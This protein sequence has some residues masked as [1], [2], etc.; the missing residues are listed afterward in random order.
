MN[1][2]L[3]IAL[4]Q[5]SIVWENPKANRTILSQKLNT[6]KSDVD[7]IILP[8]MFTSG[9]TMNPKNLEDSEGENTVAWMQE[10][11]ATKNMAI[12]GSIPFYENN[13]YTN[14][15]FFITADGE[16]Y[17]YDKKHTFTLA[18][19]DK[20]Y[21]SGLKRLIVSYKG[22]NICPMICYDLRFPVWARFKNDYDVLIYVANW[23]EP[24]IAAWDILL[25]A[26]AIENLSYCVGVNRIG[27]DENGLKYS[28]HSAVFDALGNQLCFST[29]EEVIYS[30]IE[31]SQL[32]NTR[33]KLM[34]LEDKDDF[35]FI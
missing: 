20:V 12:V 30:T 19:E 32:I 28:G 11:A 23:P 10:I 24:R 35:K 1:E 8:E 34:F 6:I 31:K 2:Q 16:K 3:N 17:N 15:L 21:Q 33:K 4:V 18:G 5:T 29:K 13:K 7:L 14:R 26:R 27:E 9:F 25:K 22:F